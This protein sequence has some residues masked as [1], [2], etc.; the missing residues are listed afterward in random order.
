MNKVIQNRIVLDGWNLVCDRYTLIVEF[1]LLVQLPCPKEV[2]HLMKYSIMHICKK[3]RLYVRVFSI[4]A[5]AIWR[6][7]NEIRFVI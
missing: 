7:M 3:T 2:L 4:G 1:Q 6:I 5:Q